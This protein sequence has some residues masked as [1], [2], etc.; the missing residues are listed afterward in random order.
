MFRRFALLTILSLTACSLPP[1]GILKVRN[2]TGDR[3]VATDA[4]LRIVNNAEIAPASIPGEV[5]PNRIICAE[6]SPD[7]ATTI[8]S[9]FSG[10][11]NFPN[12]GNTSISAAQVEGLVQLGERTATIQLLR[13]K[14]YQTCLAY[15]NGAI[16]GTTYSF[17]MSRLDDTIVTLLMGETAGGAFGRE[18]ASIGGKADTSASA[19][20]S[21]LPGDITNLDERIAATATAEE[22]LR[23]AEEN[24]AKHNAITPKPEDKETHDTRT[25]E[26]EAA[27]K[28]AQDKRD[29]AQRLMKDTMEAVSESAAEISKIEGGRRSRRDPGP[30]DCR[31]ASGHAGGV[32]ASGYILLGRDGLSGRTGAEIRWYE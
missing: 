16:S 4:R 7:V 27:V 32:F 21:S 31:D 24:L 15:A 5:D 30:T 6:P 26:L 8:A 2:L 13:D 19:T 10:G 11:F 12:F 22:E 29:A 17:I 28:K 23:T 1:S 25:T 14:M 3:V 9:S 18:L 20:L